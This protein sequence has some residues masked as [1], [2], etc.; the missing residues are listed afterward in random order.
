MGPPL[1]LLHVLSAL[2]LP[3]KITAYLRWDSIPVQGV[4]LSVVV[5]GLGVSISVTKGV[6]KAQLILQDLGWILTAN[7]ISTWELDVLKTPNF[8]KSLTALS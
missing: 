1:L 3:P 7:S 2:N 4:T 6:L 5:S 8:Q